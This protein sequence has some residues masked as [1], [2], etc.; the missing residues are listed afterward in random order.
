LAEVLIVIAANTPPA[1]KVRQLKTIVAARGGC[2][3]LQKA[4]EVDF[5][6][7]PNRWA[8]DFSN[9]LPVSAVEAARQPVPMASAK[10]HRNKIKTLWLST[11]PIRHF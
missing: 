6:H 9:D 5:D 8:A 10:S 7:S 2:E 1:D 11:S 4:C 3:A